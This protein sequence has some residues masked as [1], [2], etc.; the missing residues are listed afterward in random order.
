MNALP[1]S[2]PTPQEI[3][4]KLIA[5]FGI[6]QVLLATITRI[7]RQTRPPDILKAR[8]PHTLSDR[9]REDIGLPPQKTEKVSVELLTMLHRNF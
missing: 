5:D 4:D 6:R 9:M 2:K 1:V 7:L 8:V 3:I